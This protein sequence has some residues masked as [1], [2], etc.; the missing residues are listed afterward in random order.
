MK[1]SIIALSVL[2]AAFNVNANVT[3]HEPNVQFEQNLNAYG[4]GVANWEEARLTQ[5]T[6]ADSHL[7]HH[8]AVIPFNK[9]KAMDLKVIGG[10]DVSKIMLDDVNPNKQI[11]LY[12]VMRDRAS[13]QSYVVMNKNGEIIAEDYWNGTDKDTKHHL[14]SAHKSFSSMAAFIAEREGFIKLS[15]PIGKYAPELKGT[16]WENIP[17]QNFADMNAG[18]IDLPSNREG[19]H[20]ASFGAGTTGSW[21]SSMPTVM[22]Y[23]GL[24]EKE[25]KLLPPE[26]AHGQL[27]TFSDYLKVFAKEIK[28]TYKAGEVYEYK[29][30]N[31]EMLGVAITRSSGLTLAEFFDKYLWSQGGFTADA[32]MYVNQAHE[33]AASGSLNTTTRDFAIG[34]YLMA[35]GGKNH[36]G[37]QVLPKAYIDAVINGDD[38]VKQAWSKVSYEHQIFPT[39]FY[40]NQWRTATH[41]VTGRTV[42]TMI[43]VNGQ[44]SAFDHS[45]GNVVAITGAYRQ[46]SGQQMVILYMFD[47]IFNIFD[48]LDTRTEQPIGAYLD[49]K[50][51]E[52]VI[53]GESN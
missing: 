27:N 45:T 10:L 49:E 15:D 34:A 19:Y 42:S 4:A 6:M 46:P 24:V 12:D 44:Y 53:V 7:Y 26:D 21:D 5:L 51:G 40:K 39:A 41:P 38:I 18:I 11:S 37:E 3:Y 50:T 20:W 30:L 31:T 33:S 14:M 43:G 35:N 16:E 25:G 32:A 2:L 47:T 13:I 29:D 52:V 17:L 9:D 1:K 28:P 22:G 23:N 48:H 36:L 8:H